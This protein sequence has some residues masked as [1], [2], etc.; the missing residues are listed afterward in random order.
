MGKTLFD[1]PA[2]FCK[3]ARSAPNGKIDAVFHPF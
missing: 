1:I 3:K 2:K